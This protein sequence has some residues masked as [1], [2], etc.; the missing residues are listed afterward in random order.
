MGSESEK[1]ESKSEGKPWRWVIIGAVIAL[2]VALTT[3]SITTS[4][5]SQFGQQCSCPQVR[6]LFYPCLVLEE[7]K[8]NKLRKFF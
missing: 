8:E 4:K 5:I 2:I 3:A 1:K 6:F 7:T